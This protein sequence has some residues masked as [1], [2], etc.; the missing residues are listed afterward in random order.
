MQ[1]TQT[2]NVGWQVAI[3][4]YRNVTPLELYE[5][6]E[7]RWQSRERV[8]NR[9]VF[10]WSSILRLPGGVV[11]RAKTAFRVWRDRRRVGNLRRGGYL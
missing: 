3:E 5:E 11:A 8:R 2:T 4:Y 1:R 10:S 9:P 6:A 7:E